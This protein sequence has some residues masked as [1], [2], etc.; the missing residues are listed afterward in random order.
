[1]YTFISILIIIVSILLTIVVL[2]QN[3]KGGGLAANFAAGNQTFGV[4]QTAE[5]LEKTTWGLAIT[6]LV[7]CLLAT[8]TIS[9]GNK[10]K[11]S[12]IQEKL[13]QAAPAQGQ[14]DFPVLPQETTPAE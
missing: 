4:R 12:D 3:S 8:S 7:L 10:N 13:E 5:K 1:M 9:S 6:L 2:V 11:G 14:P